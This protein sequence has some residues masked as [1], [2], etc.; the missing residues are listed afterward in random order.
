MAEDLFKV[1][2][3]LK[4]FHVFVYTGNDQDDAVL[5]EAELEDLR[6]MGLI[7]LDEYMQAK[8]LLA[9]VKNRH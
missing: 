8:L 6:E 2:E 7:E 5:M 1:R 4:R 9:R 3:L